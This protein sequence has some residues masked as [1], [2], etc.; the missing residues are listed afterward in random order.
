MGSEQS[1]ET[2]AGNEQDQQD[3]AVMAALAKLDGQTWK[4]PK[5][6][7]IEAEG[8]GALAGTSTE[9]Q[10]KL[11]E[12]LHEP[13]KKTV[14]AGQ[15]DDGWERHVPVVEDQTDGACDWLST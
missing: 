2:A 11:G 10:R 1:S 12:Q 15:S 8:T 5:T 13:P 9:E 7:P 6:P 14:A 4:K 3:A